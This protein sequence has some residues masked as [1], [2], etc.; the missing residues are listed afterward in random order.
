M[1]RSE[2][3]LEVGHRQD[4]GVQSHRPGT[5]Q[6]QGVLFTQATMG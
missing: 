5:A 3:S 1:G 4:C 2:Q 6:L